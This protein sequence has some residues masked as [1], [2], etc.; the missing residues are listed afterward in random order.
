MY[1]KA[2]DAA[3]FACIR[4]RWFTYR[5]AGARSRRQASPRQRV[6]CTRRAASRGVFLRRLNTDDF[7]SETEKHP[8]ASPT[9]G[10]LHGKGTTPQACSTPAPL[11]QG[12]LKHAPTFVGA[13]THRPPMH[14]KSGRPMVAPTKRWGRCTNAV[15]AKKEPF[16]GKVLFLSL[17]NIS[18]LH[19]IYQ[20]FVSGLTVSPACTR[21]TSA[22]TLSNIVRL[23]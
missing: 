10:L 6:R 22:I 8:E 12:S 11:A 3:F 20:Y 19:I 2:A 15:P 5:R 18:I 9:E 14:C 1:K 13:T 21:R 23:T 7:A 17:Y 4:F 16:R